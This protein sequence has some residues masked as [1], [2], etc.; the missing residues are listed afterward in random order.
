MC[1]SDPCLIVLRYPF[2]ESD[3]FHQAS[4][5]AACVKKRSNILDL[6]DEEGEND[7]RQAL[8]SSADE[9]VMVGYYL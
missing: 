8:I 5:E 7:D 1:W 6:S 9:R 3:H 4:L 2:S